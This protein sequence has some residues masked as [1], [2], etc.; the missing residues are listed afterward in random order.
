M[1]DYQGNL[2]AAEG[3]AEFADFEVLFGIR[4][5]GESLEEL[6]QPRISIGYTVRN[7]HLILLVLTVKL[8][9]Q[10]KH[11]PHIQIIDMRCSQYPSFKPHILPILPPP[12]F[13]LLEHLLRKYVRPHTPGKQTLVFLE[14]TDVD[15]VLEQLLPPSHSKVK[16]LQ[17]ARCVAV[18]SHEAVVFSLP[19]LH[20]A[21][22]VAALEERIEDEVVFSLPVLSA[23]GTVG[24][25]HI[26]WGF[27]VIVW[28]WESFVVPSVVCIFIARAQVDH[29]GFGLGL[30]ECPADELVEAFGLED[31]GYGY[32]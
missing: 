30:P 19:H 22:Q 29:S 27:D 6:D 11:L 10:P 1:D 3:I 8:K 13:L 32:R 2:E 25:L 4:S 28:K 9:R 5:V 31:D 23:E 24:E 12:H 17:M 18:H 16:P 14:V 15:F 7:L 21:V 26:V 20:H